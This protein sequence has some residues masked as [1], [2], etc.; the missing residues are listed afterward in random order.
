MS[1]KTIKVLISIFCI[2]PIY[3]KLDKIKHGIIFTKVGNLI[4]HTNSLHFLIPIH[5]DHYEMLLSKLDESAILGF[6]KLVKFIPEQKKYLHK[7]NRQRNIYLSTKG[8]L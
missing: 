1:F 5:L 3:A 4:K 8:L 2:I 7:Y 6:D